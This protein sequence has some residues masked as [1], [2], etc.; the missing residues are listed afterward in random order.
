[1]IVIRLQMQV[2]NETNG[3]LCTSNK[4]E[5]SCVLKFNDYLTQYKSGLI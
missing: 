3:Y 5:L 4:S 1:M 2:T